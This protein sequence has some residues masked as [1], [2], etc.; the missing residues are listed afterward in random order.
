MG[1]QERALLTH[2]DANN[3]Y[4][5]QLSIQLSSCRDAWQAVSYRGFIAAAVPVEVSF[6][7]NGHDS[8]RSG[9][10]G[11]SPPL[12]QLVVNVAENSADAEHNLRRRKES[13]KKKQKRESTCCKASFGGR[14][15]SMRATS[16]TKLPGG[17][18]CHQLRGAAPLP[19]RKIFQ[20]A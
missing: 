4:V 18:M 11:V 19:R 15:D 3:P 9:H 5:S 20:V 13:K 6:R 8:V 2:K 14:K 10:R 7:E 1:N 12:L 16:K 17:K